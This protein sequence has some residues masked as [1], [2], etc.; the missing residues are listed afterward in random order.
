[1]KLVHLPEEFRASCND[2][3]K[4]GHSVGL[5]PTM[6]ALHSGHASLMAAARNHGSK[7]CVTI[8]VNPT[9]FGPNEDFGKYPRTLENDLAICQA[10]GTEVV[11]APAAGDMYPAGDATRVRVS[12]LTEVLCGRSRPGHFDGVT[13]VVSK[14]FALAGPCR[15]FFGRKD[16]QQLQ[17]VKR[18]TA[19]L[20][21]PVEVI[22]CPI[23]READ[24]LAL[25]SRN[26]Y[27]DADERR[28]ALG[29]VRGLVRAER[30]YRTGERQGVVLRGIIEESLNA[31]ELRAD[32]VELRGTEQLEEQTSA[33]S[34]A[35]MS[36]VLVAAFCGVTRLIDNFVLGTEPTALL[37]LVEG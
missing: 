15:A 30:A 9:Q 28:R 25:S 1:M 19:D 21:L 10:E 6:G 8:F 17:V 37:S 27:L 7:P 13:T 23:V 24:G 33:S 5:V 35:G 36:V 2:L 34:V 16:Y 29:I 32:Y 14:F 12:G 31:S 3:R 26:R 11:F 22:S 4:L 18:M 20:M